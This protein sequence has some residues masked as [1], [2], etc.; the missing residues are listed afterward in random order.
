MK[1][2]NASAIDTTAMA[3]FV[4]NVVFIELKCS[5][6]FNIVQKIGLYYLPVAELLNDQV[7]LCPGQLV[8]VA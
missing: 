5:P 7:D 6:S 8:V 4:T 2:Y 1:N 3:L